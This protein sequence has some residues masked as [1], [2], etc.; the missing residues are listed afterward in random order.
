MKFKVSFKIL[1][2]IF[3]AFFGAFAGVYLVSAD[4]LL[5]RTDMLCP[6]YARRGVLARRTPAAAIHKVD[7]FKSS[8]VN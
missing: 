6:S 1:R 8:T 7:D 5:D 4:L 3:V 2:C